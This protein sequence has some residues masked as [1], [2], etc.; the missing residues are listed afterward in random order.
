MPDHPADEPRGWRRAFRLPTGR[1][2]AEREVDDEIAFHLAMRE[3]SLRRGGLSD[4]GAHR[5]ARERFGDVPAIRAAALR[6]DVPRVTRVQVGTLW[7][8]AAQDVHVALRTLRRAPGFAAVAVLTLALGIG[9]ATAVF[10]VAY[11]VLLRPL[12]FADPGRLVQVTT[13]YPASGLEQSYLSDPEFHELRT[14]VPALAAVA[15][16]NDQQRTLAGDAGGAPP[17][18]LRIAAVTADLLPLLGVRPLLGRGFDRAEDRPGAEPVIVLGHALWQ[19]RFGADPTVVGRALLLDGVSRTVLGVLPP[20]V[21]LAD[22]QA[23]IPL[24]LDPANPRNRG[25]HYLQVVGRLRPEASPERLRT[26]LAA[27][28]RRSIADHPAEYGDPSFSMAAV[29]LRDAWV[30]ETRPTLL[31]L[32]GAVGLLLLLACVNVANLLLVRA[33]ARGREL[34]VRAALGAGRGRLARQLLA[35]TLLLA[36]AGALVGLPLAVLGVRGLLALNPGVVPGGTS[37]G[38]DAT[39]LLAA[40]TVVAAAT[41]LAGLAPAVQAGRTDVRTAI[42]AGAVGGGRRGARLRGV[43]V[44]GQIAVATLVLV[45]AGLVGRSFWRLQQVDPGFRPAPVL[46]FDLR[47][48]PQRPPSDTLVDDAFARLLDRLRAVPGVRA[49]AAVSHLPMGGNEGDWTVD[50]EGREERP[51]EAKLSPDFAIATEGYFETIGI[52]LLEG[53]A[54]GPGD[55]ATAPPAVVVSRRLADALWPGV[56]ALGRRMRPAGPPGRESPWMTVVG[57]AGD[58]RADAL[59]AEPRPTYYMLDRQFPHMVGGTVRDMAVVVR[60]AC[61][62]TSCR[63]ASLGSAVRRAVNELEPDLAVANLRPLRTVVAATVGRQ[64]F[65]AAVLALFGA[66]ALLLAVVGVYG[67]LAS[68]VTRRRREMGIRL[69]LGARA[70]QVRGLVVRSGLALAGAG[71]LAGLLAALLGAPLLGTVLYDVSATDPVTFAGTVLLLGGAALAA[72]WV[73]AR[74]ATRVD[75]AEALRPD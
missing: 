48:M 41:L 36:L 43:L 2:Q 54:F 11:G 68:S 20:A 45:G 65:A 47:L 52:P 26:E 53:R 7:R 55:A 28:A 61:D 22:Y 59:G 5:R 33:E 58:V 72:S 15:A 27:F 50:V 21:R 63:P 14:A 29:S 60:A 24:R 62:G 39:V 17:E 57:I 40:A 38:V 56:S 25:A 10:S 31:V 13:V 18:R 32:L 67:V 42:A 30:G 49:A 70:G 73:P 46:T 35:E 44:A 4:T 8:D 12:P 9:A 71:L 23:L 37:V 64:R 3:A 69:A 51:G 16:I 19:R 34:G 66:S 6:E 75:P 74:R 1:R